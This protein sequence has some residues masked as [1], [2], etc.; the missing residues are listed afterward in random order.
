MKMKL[1]G[2]YEKMG[3]SA[4]FSSRKGADLDHSQ[5]QSVHHAFEAE[6][7]VVKD[8]LASFSNYLAAT[9]GINVLKVEAR[10][11]D[12]SSLK[13][14]MNGKWKNKTLSEGSDFVGGR[15]VFRTQDEVNAAI[16]ELQSH[17]GFTP[18]EH[19]D[20]VKSPRPGGYRAHHIILRTP[21]GMNIEM[22]M[23][24]KNQSIGQKYTHDIYKPPAGSKWASLSE[25]ELGEASAYGEQVSNYL[26][27]LDSGE[28]PG[29]RPEAPKALE[30]RGL[31]FDWSKAEALHY[32]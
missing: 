22:Q 9:Q 18:I 24:T 30:S 25:Q 10:A 20:F 23:Q 4:T 31:A 5:I 28:I 26:A 17:T 21:N 16:A 3:K 29:Q 2:P 8:K 1:T 13:D 11:K 7:G 14:K 15:M 27:A 19:D 12:V 6:T 32:E